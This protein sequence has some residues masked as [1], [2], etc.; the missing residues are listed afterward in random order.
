[1]WND[2]DVASVFVACRRE[3]TKKDPQHV[4]CSPRP[5]WSSLMWDGADSV[6]FRPVSE[7]LGLYLPGEE[8]V[9]VNSVDEVPNSS[10]FTNR[11]GVAPMTVED[12]QRGAC[13]PS[14]ILHPESAGEGT[15]V[16]DKGK[17][18]GTT[19]GFRIKVSGHNYLLKIDE[20]AQP[21]LGSAAQTIGLAIYHAAGFNTPCEQIVYFKP[22][23]LKLS[24]GLRYKG[25]NME[26]EKEFDQKALDAILAKAVRRGDRIRM[27][28][29]AWLAGESVGPFRYADTRH[30]DPNDVIKHQD[31]RE[32]RG[33]RLIAAWIDHTDAREGNSLDTWIADHEDAP[34]SSPGHIVHYM[35]DTGEALGPR[36]KNYE[37]VTR[38][39]GYGYVFDWGV[40]ASDFAGIGIPRHPWDYIQTRPGHELFLYFNV[41]DFVPDQWKNEYSNTA[42]SRMTERD[43]AWMARILARFTPEMVHGLAEIGRFTDPE[44]TEYLA[45]V[46]EGR[47]EKILDRYL[48]RLSPIAD[49]QMKDA[50]R[51]CGFDLAEWR[52]VRAPQQ[53]R[54]T[55][56]SSRSGPLHVERRGGGAICVRVPHVAPDGVIADDSP[57]RYVVVTIRD[58]VAPGPLRAHLYDLG[59][60]RGHRLVGIERRPQ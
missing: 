27:E 60:I 14:L 32:L 42:F 18:E 59:P 24:P 49:V 47:L 25:G 13:D 1:M 31:R 41:T 35:L 28:A 19:A 16:I 26:E 48:T 17:V 4:N 20:P 7:A 22:S 46:L 2:T 15:W 12:V 55:A 29:S 36:W 11:I 39:A 30:D 53:F 23:I 43:A 44:N 6:I 33:S 58:G 5:Y 37:P 57:A 8:A 51:L 56:N 3:A 54:Y 40:F 10:W 9:N 45:T 21:E 52:E 38:R 34:E 50:N